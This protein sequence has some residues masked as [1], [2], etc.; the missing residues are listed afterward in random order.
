MSLPFCPDEMQLCHVYL[1]CQKGIL[2]EGPPTFPFNWVVE[3]K[4]Q[5]AAMGKKL[6]RLNIIGVMLAS[7][8]LINILMV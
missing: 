1:H 7:V 3:R 6:L 4:N 8:I 2:S 5:G